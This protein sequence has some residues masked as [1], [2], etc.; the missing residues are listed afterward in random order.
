MA[1]VIATVA[2]GFSQEYS[3]QSA[4]AALRLRCARACT[5]SRRP[6]R[7]DC[8]RRRRARR[9]VGLSAGSLVPAD[10]VLLEATD[11]FVSEA[12]LTGES[13]PGRK[14]GRPRRRDAACRDR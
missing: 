2:V 7:A 9:L 4:A 13:F 10:G 14:A 11:F 6:S 1:I 5:V 8:V 3:A 12:V